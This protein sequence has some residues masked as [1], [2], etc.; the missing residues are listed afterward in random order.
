MYDCEGCGPSRQ[1]LFFGSGIGEAKWWCWRCQSADQKELI[2]YLDDHARG[3]LSRD[4]DGVHWPYGPNIYVQMRADLLDWADRHDLKNGN[5]GCSSRLHWL[6]RGRCAKR[7]CQGRPEFYDH[8]TTW[9]SRT[10]GKPALVFNQPYRQVDPAEVWDAISEYPS[11][12]AEVGPESWY[13]AGTSGVYIWN[14]G[15]RSMAVRSS[16]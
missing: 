7:E 11:L 10:T 1:G 4:A 5:T 12:T 9:L 6:D 16:R 2:R 15:N 14:D 8:T 3:V 13:G